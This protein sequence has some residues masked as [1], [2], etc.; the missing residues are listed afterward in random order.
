MDL[1]L[2]RLTVNDDATIGSMSVDG[3]EQCFTLEPSLFSIPAGVYP[4]VI[5][6]S[7]H[8]QKKVPHVENVPDRTEIEIHVG[9]TAAD[10]KGCILVGSKVV[11]DTMISGSDAAWQALMVDI[12]D[13]EAN[14]EKVTLTVLDTGA[15]DGQGDGLEPVAPERG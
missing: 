12:T 8:F 7:N 1:K 3:S 11:S 2:Q 5:A 14:N 6:W 13:A 9:N 4:V 15:Q 10:S